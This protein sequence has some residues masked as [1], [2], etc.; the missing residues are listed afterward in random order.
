[1]QPLIQDI[2]SHIIGSSPY[3]PERFCDFSCMRFLFKT[4]QKML[5]RV[6]SFWSEIYKNAKNG[7]ECFK[8]IWS[9]TFAICSPPTFVALIQDWKQGQDKLLYPT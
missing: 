2:F 4:K 9:G 6:N 7:S 3:F 1:M 8:L 5:S